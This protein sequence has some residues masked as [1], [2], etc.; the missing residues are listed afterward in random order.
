[1]LTQDGPVLIEIA[2]RL[3]GDHIPLFAERVTGISSAACALAAAMEIDPPKP[4]PAH[5]RIAA[6]QYITAP[7]LAGETYKE[8]DGWNTIMKHPSV[9]M[10]TIDIHPGEKIPP[11]NDE[12]SRLAKVEFHAD[13]VGDA[14]AFRK[15]IL[16]T[17][18]VIG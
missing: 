3:P 1:M 17:V 16:E 15:K 12:R 4:K 6:S 13:S 7:N 18:H 10:M 8:L 5:T 9:D 11:D 2:N 14:Q